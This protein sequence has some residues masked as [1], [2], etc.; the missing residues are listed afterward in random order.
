MI[1]LPNT[2]FLADASDR[3]KSMMAAQARPVSL[4]RGQVLFDQGDPGDAL[5]AVTDGALEVSVLSLQGRKLALDLM[6]PGA[7][8]GE[9]S[10]FDPG[11][12]TATITA[13]QPSQVL[14]VRNADILAQINK[15]PELAGDMIRLAGLRMR[16][17]GRQLNEQVFL[18]VPTR[19][20]RKLL[21]L[22]PVS[23]SCPKTVALSQ[24]ELAEYVG[25]TREA[26]SKTIAAWK[27]LGV[28]ETV[29]SGILIQDL[30]ALHVLA[31]LE[32]I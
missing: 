24:T 3:L 25:A 28:I 18:P 1:S 7:I 19:L 15:H 16:W 27:R 22:A 32:Q 10:L 8:F 2:G 30:E 17:M 6:G 31:D 20:A 29:R 13:T 26:I 11:P 12:R 9:I 21:H 5:F 23:D 14:R 4:S